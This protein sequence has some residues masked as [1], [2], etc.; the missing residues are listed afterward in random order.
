MWCKYLPR[1][2][3]T[4]PTAYWSSKWKPKTVSTKYFVLKVYN[5]WNAQTG[6]VLSR[7]PLKGSRTPYRKK[8]YKTSFL[9]LGKRTAA[10][11]YNNDTTMLFP[12][13]WGNR[14]TGPL[15]CHVKYPR[16][17]CCL[18]RPSAFS[19]LAGLYRLRSPCI[20]TP[21]VKSHAWFGA[22]LCPFCCFIPRD[23]Y[24]NY[25]CIRWIL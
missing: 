24:K 10:L 11:L 1:K 6:G 15:S 3:Y 17:I 9:P 4:Y 22:K 20:R 18:F 23:E 14:H 19:N 16:N 25:T 5:V 13:T 2:L 12:P 7:W 8:T 21:F